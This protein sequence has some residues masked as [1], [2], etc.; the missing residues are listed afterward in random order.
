MVYIQDI[1]AY[2]SSPSLSG[3]SQQR[4]PSQT[5]PQIFAVTTISVSTY[6]SRQRPLVQC[7]HSFL[8]NRVALLERDYCTANVCT[9]NH[10]EY[11]KNRSQKV[12]SPPNNN[13]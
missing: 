5:R 4:P 13:K 1:L 7:G 6:P 9:L 10:L 11:M 8:A 12:L 3:H 2:Y